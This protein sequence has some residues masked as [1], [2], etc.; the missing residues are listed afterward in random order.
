MRKSSCIWTPACRLRCQYA[1]RRSCDRPSPLRFDVVFLGPVADTS[2]VPQIPKFHR[3]S[4]VRSSYNYSI[5]VSACCVLRDQIWCLIQEHF[6]GSPAVHHK[7]ERALPD[8]P[9]NRRYFYFVMQGVEHPSSP[10][11]RLSGSGIRQFHQTFLF[12]FLSRSGINS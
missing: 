7:D 8:V 4:V 5:S 2:L 1:S 10:P 12:Y 3:M 6:L 11:C 9:R